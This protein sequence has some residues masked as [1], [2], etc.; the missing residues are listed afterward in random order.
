[1]PT[2]AALAATVALVRKQGVSLG[3]LDTAA[4]L[5]ALALAWRC[6]PHQVALAESQVNAALREF[7]T[8]GGAF[9]RIDHV[10]LR[11]WLVDEGWLSRDGFGREYRAPGLEALPAPCRD[12]ALPLVELDVNQW[13]M[14]LRAQAKAEAQRRRA[15]WTE[16]QHNDDCAAG[17]AA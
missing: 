11:R 14:G 9:L 13:V 10:E 5:R 6:L 17:S 12:A 4:R 8:R 7:L 1:M 15:A 2:G 16:R 3:L